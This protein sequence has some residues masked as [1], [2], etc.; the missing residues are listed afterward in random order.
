[1]WFSD[2]N[3]LLQKSPRSAGKRCELNLVDRTPS[4]QLMLNGKCES[5][6][7][8]PRISREKV[9]DLPNYQALRALFKYFDG[10]LEVIGAMEREI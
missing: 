3:R 6:S 1:M 2:G 9:L 4:N 8:L 7:K 10:S 5:L